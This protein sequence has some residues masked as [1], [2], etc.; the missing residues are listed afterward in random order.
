MFTTTIA[1]FQT[2][3]ANACSN[4][5][6]SW[7]PVSAA[8][9]TLF[10][11]HCASS[12][13]PMSSFIWCATFCS[14]NIQAMNL[15]DIL[16]IAFKSNDLIGLSGTPHHSALVWVNHIA[17]MP[18]HLK[19]RFPFLIFLV[20]LHCKSMLLST[21]CPKI[22]CGDSHC[23][24]GTPIAVCVLLLQPFVA[25]SL[26]DVWIHL[27]ALMHVG[28][29][30]CGFP[31][32]TA[33]LVFMFTSMPDACPMPCAGTPIVVWVLFLWFSIASSLLDV[34][35]HLHALMHAQ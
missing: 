34:H 5:L 8:N 35:I 23:G 3:V 9:H 6:L 13:F 14:L 12:P 10:E 11:C 24:L 32:P 22:T 1:E 27:H 18:A 33:C 30:F 7:G 15:V 28:C 4:A 29:S 19:L 2:P 20:S 31:L 21:N 16:H 17:H 25:S 26:L